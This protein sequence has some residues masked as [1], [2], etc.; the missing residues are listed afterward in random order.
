MPPSGTSFQ[1]FFQWRNDGL[2]HAPL[3]FLGRHGNNSFCH[4]NLF[5]LEGC[6]VSQA[7]AA[8]VKA[9]AHHV[10]PFPRQNFGQ[11]LRFFN[12]KG[13]PFG[14]IGPVNFAGTHSLEGIVREEAFVDRL[15]KGCIQSVQIDAY[16]LGTQKFQVSVHES[17]RL[18]FRHHVQRHFLFRPQKVQKALNTF[19]VPRIG[20]SVGTCRQPLNKMF[21]DAGNVSLV[22][23]DGFGLVPG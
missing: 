22:A 8:C 14:G 12:R 13:S 19:S 11:S 2:V 21:L 20:T 9:Y 15:L 7:L 17:L 1:D 23:Q 10:G 4:V 6:N 5:P 16:R 3:G 18:S